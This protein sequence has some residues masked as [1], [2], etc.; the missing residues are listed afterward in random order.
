MVWKLKKS[1]KKNVNKQVYG[2]KIMP[3]AC[4]MGA[5]IECDCAE[6]KKAPLLV[7]PETGI[8]SST[9]PIAAITAIKPSNI[10]FGACKASLNPV[11][12]L[13]APKGPCTI[14]P[15]GPWIKG[16]PK[17]MTKQGPMLTKDSKLFCSYGGQIKINMGVPTLKAN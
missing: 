10:N 14:S 13:G 6:S 5:I 1:L 9:G 3:D 4:A 7:T 11:V 17:V 15:A 12:L 2:G 16:T 8:M